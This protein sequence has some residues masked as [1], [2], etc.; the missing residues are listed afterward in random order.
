MPEETAKEKIT[1]S[2]E[3][4]GKRSV[5]RLPITAGNKL[6]VS[7]IKLKDSTES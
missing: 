7:K 2:E 5:V 4:L 1:I 6:E 3:F